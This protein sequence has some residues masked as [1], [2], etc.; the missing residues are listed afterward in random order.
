TL[1]PL[2]YLSIT[3]IK[4][5]GCIQQQDTNT[6]SASISRHLHQPPMLNSSDILSGLGKEAPYPHTKIFAVK[7]AANLTYID[8]TFPQ[9]SKVIANHCFLI[10]E[11]RYFELII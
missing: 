8:C 6:S 9:S 1:N 3:G 11:E 4:Q 7:S 2:A 5:P 10:S